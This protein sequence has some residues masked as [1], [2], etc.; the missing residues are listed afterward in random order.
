MIYVLGAGLTAHEKRD[1][2]YYL[3]WRLYAPSASIRLQVRKENGKTLLVTEIADKDGGRVRSVFRMERI[4]KTSAAERIKAV[5][6]H[7]RLHDQKKQFM[8]DSKNVLTKWL[9]SES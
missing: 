2:A 8:G 7:D 3:L 1:D 6:T 5:L 4:E 9:A